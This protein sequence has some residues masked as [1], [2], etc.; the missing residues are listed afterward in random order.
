MRFRYQIHTTTVRTD[1]AFVTD[2]GGRS[3]FYQLAV[4][5]SS[6]LTTWSNIQETNPNIRF[7]RTFSGIDLAF[8]NSVLQT[9]DGGYIVAGWTFA[10]ATG[11]A[12]R[13]WLLKTD[14]RGNELW[15]R[16]YDDEGI[17]A[18]PN[19]EGVTSIRQTGDGGFIAVGSRLFKT[20]ESGEVEW[21]NNDIYGF[22]IDVTI[23]GYI[24][25][26]SFDP[27]YLF[28][29]VHLIKVNQQGAV[30]WERIL[31]PE[32]SPRPRAVQWTTDRG[33]I[34]TGSI[35]TDENSDL[36][37]LKTD[38]WGEEEWSS[39]YGGSEN[40]DGYSVQQT[41]DGGFVTTGYTYSEVPYS[42]RDAWLL[43]T[44]SAG[45]EEWNRCFGGSDY[46]R[47]RS[48]QQTFDGGYMLVGYTDGDAWLIKTSST[49]H[50][51]WDQTYGGPEPEGGMSGEQ[52]ADGG[53]IITGATGYS[54]TMLLIK[55]DR[56]GNVN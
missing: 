18:D 38:E 26:G 10:E 9:F 13:S 46:D 28:P 7:S 42:T 5:D 32:Q 33:Y 35:T 20:D 15:S 37:L 3:R 2:Y 40:E 8:G 52:T 47:A 27:V 55:T 11:Y 49:G 17:E 48:V 54:Q 16:I 30:E 31:N 44:D 14:A 29:D 1:T 22:S 6:G 24:I 39:S 41:A 34:I 51:L 53:Y 23:D 36:W 21:V 45:N 4:T 56:E 19:F 50:L 43:K 12:Y 25:L